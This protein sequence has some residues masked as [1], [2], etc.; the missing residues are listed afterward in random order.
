[1]PRI[2]SPEIPLGNKVIRNYFVLIEDEPV[3]SLAPLAELFVI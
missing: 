1:M 2:S 3:R